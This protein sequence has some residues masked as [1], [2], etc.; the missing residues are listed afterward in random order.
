M[1][2]SDRKR[3][4]LKAI[5]DDYIW[6]A[7]PVGSKALVTRHD[8]DVSSATVRNEM[9]ELEEM[10]YLEK[11]HKSAGRVPSDK[12]Y[13]AYVDELLS[14]QS[15]PESEQKAIEAS[16]DQN[17]QEIT[18]LIKS[19][20]AILA[21][22]TDFPSIV[23]TPSYADTSLQQIKILMIEPGKAL[24]VV[25]LSAG[26]VRDRIIRVPSEI[27]PEELTAIAG[28]IEHGLSGMKLDDI[29][30]VTVSAAAG[31]SEVPESLLNQILFEAYVS[32]KQ[33]EN[34]DVYME[35]G[36]QLLNQPEFQDPKT[37]HRVIDTI[38]RDHLVAGYMRELKEEE[39]FGL[40]RAEV[41]DPLFAECRLDKPAKKP[42]YVVRIG[43]EIS[44]DGLEEC[45]FITTT[46]RLTDRITGRIGV[47]GPK[48]MA[49]GKLISQ[50][51]FF[52]RTLTDEIR[53]IAFGD[54]EQEE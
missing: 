51:N 54:E 23:L 24:V 39:S 43:Q 5:V 42:G 25:V 7:E 10:G 22:Q 28:A 49:Y 47:V 52:N 29:T 20:A 15:L 48:R 14:V 13:R 53:K 18:E 2:L 40:E 31:R 41:D 46:Y 21:S 3:K 32:I 4:I 11:P 44:L 50:I 30:M 8:L 26:V 12:G 17:V 6:T 19:S 36:H 1:L 45:S 35:G 27:A 34:I 37:A 9:G 33:A 16:F 38:S